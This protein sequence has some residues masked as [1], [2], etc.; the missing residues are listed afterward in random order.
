MY[1]LVMRTQRTHRYGQTHLS[2]QRRSAS[3]AKNQKNL[4]GDKVEWVT[5]KKP[6]A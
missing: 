3:I 1:G 2:T 5:K 4:D 6:E